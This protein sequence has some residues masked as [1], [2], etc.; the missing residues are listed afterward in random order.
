MVTLKK[1]EQ[2]EYKLSSLEYSVGDFE[3]NKDWVFSTPKITKAWLEESD[4]LKSEDKLDR[5]FEKISFSNKSAIEELEVAKIDFHKKLIRLI[6]NEPIEDGYLHPA[7]EL[8]ESVLDKFKTLSPQWIESVYSK[9]LVSHSTISASILRC[10]GRLPEVLVSPWAI[11]IAN[12][13]LLQTNVELREAAIRA[14]E[15]WGTEESLESLKKYISTENIPWLANYANQ[16]IEDLLCS[17]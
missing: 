13:A 1:D 8:I 11:K 7:E 4:F 16:V 5:T 14:F 15:N 10:I 12:E 17:N 3:T 6:E 2:I 9:N